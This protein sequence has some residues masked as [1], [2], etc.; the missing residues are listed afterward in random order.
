MFICDKCGASI[1]EGSKFCPQCGDP[2]TEADKVTVLL[3]EKQIANVEIIFGYS[4]SPNYERAAEIC[5]NIPSYSTSG[6]GNQTQHKISLPI[7]E[8]DLLLNLYDLVGS[9]KT[10]RMLIN[11]HS[12]TKKAISL[13]GVGCYRNRQRAYIPEQYCFGEQ[14]YE[15]NI[16]GCKRLGLPV[17]QWGGGWLDYG[18]FDGS[19]AW[20]FDKKRIEHELKI[21]LKN[22]ELCPV[23][24]EKRVSQTLENIPDSINPQHDKNWQYRT[25]Y[26]EADGDYREVAVGIKPVIKKINRYVYGD[27]KPKWTV[28]GPS[29]DIEGSVSD[30]IKI[31]FNTQIAESTTKSEE[32]I[33]DQ[34]E[35]WVEN[36]RNQPE[37]IKYQQWQKLTMPQRAQ[38]KRIYKLTE[39]RKPGIGCLTVLGVMLVIFVILLI[40]GAFL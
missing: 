40:L 6:E 31:S 29:Q 38:L 23:L 14:E 13:G 4:S 30:G 36:Y 5:K 22:N 10:S 15:A 1:V 8:V 24:D 19:G 27:Y 18:K 3:S 39:P 21:A 11:G 16:W 12:S 33:A 32:S 28:E 20:H 9:W 7:T 34:W 25:S 37:N 2:V 17:T 26:E 35:R